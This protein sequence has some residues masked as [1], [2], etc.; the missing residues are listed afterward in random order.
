MGESPFQQGFPS[1]PDLV[2][3]ALGPPL[4]SEEGQEV[5]GKITGSTSPLLMEPAQQVPGTP[6]MHMRHSQY[7]E[8]QPMIYIHPENSYP[9]SEVHSYIA[10]GHPK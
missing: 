1:L 7:I 6:G 8:L 3:G 5:L 4:L 9:L 2:W 10:L